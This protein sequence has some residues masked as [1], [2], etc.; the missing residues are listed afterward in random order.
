M[1]SDPGARRL[2]A[3]ALAAGLSAALSAAPL[4][5]QQT[6][7]FRSAVTLVTVDVSVLD[8]DGKPVPGLTPGDFEVKLNGRATPVRVLTFVQA[9]GELTASKPSVVPAQPKPDK[10]VRQGRQTVNNEGVVAAVKPA[11][12]DRVFVVLIDDLSF[13]P[14]RGKALFLSARKFIDELPAVDLVGLAT[15]SGAVSINP[16]ADRRRVRDA[17]ARAAGEA[18]DPQSLTPP[19]ADVADTAEYDA[20]GSVGISQAVD[21]DAG[22]MDVLKKAIADGCFN[23]D[24]A[25]V[26]AQVLD[27]LIATNTC[28]GQV[29][30]QART[31]AARTR[32]TTRRQVGS[33]VGVLEAMQAAS[34]LKHL[35]VLSDGLAIGRDVDQLKPVAKAAATAGV[36]VSVLMEERDLSLSDGGRRATAIGATATA[37]TGAPQRRIEDNKMFLAGGQLA[38]ELA[39]GQFHRVIGQPEPFFARVRTASAAVYRLGLEPLPDVDAS[40]IASVEAKVNRRGVFVHANRH[41]VAPASSALPASEPTVDDRLRAAVGQGHS[42]G[43]VP[44]RV[45]TTVR[46]TPGAQTLDL[47]INASVPAAVPGAA[48]GPITAMFGLTRVPAPGEPLGTL[49]SGRGTL[50]AA[51]SGAFQWSVSVPTAPGSYLLRVAVA[52]ATGALG[53]LEVP[54]EAELSAMGPLVA[55]DIVTAWVDS[56]G[57]PH[58]MALDELPAAATSLQVLFELYAPPGGAAGV[59]EALKDDVQVEVTVTRVGD[60]EPVDSR[61]I[62]PRLVD[63]TLRALVEFARDDWRAG[64]YH[65]RARVRSSDQIVGS[66]LSVVKVSAR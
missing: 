36:Q 14:L 59:L 15:T 2:R 60:P 42:H 20:D 48:A 18:A 41:G 35:V 10:G 66:A 21:I 57:A 45:A 32:Q 61:D 49:M 65:V 12:E 63:G 52:D 39:G 6:P 54:V 4:G 8:G 27:V 22:D 28:A 53:A 29:Q 56:T 19:G 3:A 40:R 11:G 24:R 38:A 26:N 50:T 17:L 58:V 33:Y 44:L 30:R 47:H 16:T 43:A 34:G 31:I 62:A 1:V 13:A 64:T 51:S 37:D 25:Q 23:G 7:A 46:R 9:A 5:G 55:S